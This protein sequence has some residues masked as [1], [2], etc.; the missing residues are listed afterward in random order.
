V[1]AST[2]DRML[3]EAVGAGR[4]ELSEI[5]SKQILEAIGIPVAAA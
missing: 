2:I 4:T 1:D 5:E 3:A